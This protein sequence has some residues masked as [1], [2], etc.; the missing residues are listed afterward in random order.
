MTTRRWLLA[1]VKAGA[2]PRPPRRDRT[3]P[4]SP[5]G[6]PPHRRNGGV[7]PAATPVGQPEGS[8]DT[9]ATEKRTLGRSGVL[10]IVL[11]ALAALHFVLKP[12]YLWDSGLPQVSDFVMVVLMVCVFV[13]GRPAPDYRTLIT[14]FL[15]FSVYAATVNTVWF[16][17]HLHDRILM[18]AFFYVYNFLAFYAFFCALRKYGEQSFV[19][20]A[21][22][23]SVTLVCY[24]ILSFFVAGSHAWRG[25][26]FF[27]NPNQ[28]AYY[29]ILATCSL[30]IINH[31]KSVPLV[32]L[33]PA[34]AAATYLMMTTISRAGIV[35]IALTV[36]LVFVKRFRYA[37]AL[38][39]FAVPLVFLGPP[40]SMNDRLDSIQT[41]Y[42]RRFDQMEEGGGTNSI[43]W[44]GYNRIFEHPEHLL[45]GAGEGSEIRLGYR[46]EIHST[47][48]VLVFGYGIIGF[49]L[50][51]LG[52]WGLFR[53]AGFA[54]SLFLIPPALYGTTHQGLRF[55]TLW[56][57]L[58]VLAY[59]G[60]CL[61]RT[62]AGNDDR[63]EDKETAPS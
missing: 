15:L 40:A 41:R 23:I 24:M 14:P 22:T 30:G 43:Y 9:R 29:L 62:T 49:G 47:W 42:E 32:I 2:A 46:H 16:M 52:L 5:A 37:I 26:L 18:S 51:A 4:D 10:P 48:A 59:A 34:Y 36:F 39:L 11:I 63:D 55:T 53:I 13:F 20:L 61:Q 8:P 25:T 3:V 7:P 58:A 19:V 44:R 38:S 45:F 27:N 31:V 33:I 12:F 28:L 35:C 21:Y 57:L 50:F 17:I 1:G 60:V 56:V 6:P 54:P